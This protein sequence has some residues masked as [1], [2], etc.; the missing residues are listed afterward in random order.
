MSFALACLAI[1]LA[2]D[3]MLPPRPTPGQRLDHAIAVVRAREADVYAALDA[4]PPI[5]LP[6]RRTPPAD[7]ESIA[8]ADGAEAD[9]WV[10]GD[11]VVLWLTESP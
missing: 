9:L 2:D 5:K 3:S 11:A 4:L 10:S 1:A 7:V 8:V 6:L